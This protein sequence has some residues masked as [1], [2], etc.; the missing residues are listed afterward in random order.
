MATAIA[1]RTSNEQP[2][3]QLQDEFEALLDRFLG[4]RPTLFEAD[5]GLDDRAWGLDVDEREDEIVVRAEVPGFEPDELEVQLN[6]R[7]LTVKAE[8][9][10]TKKRNKGRH[11]ELAYRS[12]YRSLTLPDGIKADQVE[13]KYHNGVLEVHVPRSED[14]RPKRIAIEG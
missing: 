1:K 12:F 7:L 2:L 6:D 14:G 3:A 13:A 8:K 9:E 4:G 5:G 10:K 11:V